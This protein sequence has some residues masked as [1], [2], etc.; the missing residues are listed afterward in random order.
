VSDT[1]DHEGA[2]WASLEDYYNDGDGPRYQPFPRCKRCGAGG[3]RWAQLSEGVWVLR[4]AAGTPHSCP[5][6]NP[7]EDLR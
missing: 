7:F 6:T 4:D 5:I 3:L 2:A 1:F